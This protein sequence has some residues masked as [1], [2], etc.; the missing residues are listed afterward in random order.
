VLEKHLSFIQLLPCG[1][2][3]Q[4]LCAEQMGMLRWHR[5]LWT[6]YQWSVNL[7]SDEQNYTDIYRVVFIER[8]NDT[9]FIRNSQRTRS[10]KIILASQAHIV[11]KCINQIHKNYIVSHNWAGLGH[12]VS[13]LTRRHKTTKREK[14][15]LSQSHSQYCKQINLQATYT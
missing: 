15:L 12:C 9:W 7:P 14:T 4:E 2:G 11:C 8:E 6:S 13:T 10:P 3:I 5:P 1:W